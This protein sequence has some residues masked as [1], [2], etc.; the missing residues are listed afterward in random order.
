MKIFLIN[1]V[2]LVL[3]T[4]CTSHRVEQ[5]IMV[6][7]YMNSLKLVEWEYIPEEQH[8]KVLEE[9]QKTEFWKYK[10]EDGFIPENSQL[11]FIKDKNRTRYLVWYTRK[12]ETIDVSPCFQKDYSY[13]DILHEFFYYK[14]VGIDSSENDFRTYS[15]YQSNILKINKL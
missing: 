14:F 13:Q 2:A 10:D 3:A 5:D 11:F 1:I 6:D 9:V 4:S 7:Y 8:Q 15:T 12:N